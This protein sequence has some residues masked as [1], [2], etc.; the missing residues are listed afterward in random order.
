MIIPTAINSTAF[1]INL[2]RFPLIYELNAN[3]GLFIG[4][5]ARMGIKQAECQPV[6]AVKKVK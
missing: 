6:D 5:L 1:E 2:R 4:G 3:G